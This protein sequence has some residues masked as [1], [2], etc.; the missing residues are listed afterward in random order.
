MYLKIREHLYT[1]TPLDFQGGFRTKQN[2][3]RKGEK[4]RERVRGRVSYPCSILV[5]SAP[6]EMSSRVT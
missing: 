4:E 2:Q 3:D 5:I 6:N 1:Y